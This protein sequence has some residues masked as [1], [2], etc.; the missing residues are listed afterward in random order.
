MCDGFMGSLLVKNVRVD[1][2]ALEGLKV[3][4]GVISAIG[5]VL[6]PDHGS[7]II[8]GDGAIVLPGLI[9]AH[10]H[11]DKTVWGMGWPPHQAGAAL[12]DKIDTTSE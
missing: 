6:D 5:T 12:Q 1:G 9:D 11:L 10:T 8:D 3:S 4:D 2:G 7:Q